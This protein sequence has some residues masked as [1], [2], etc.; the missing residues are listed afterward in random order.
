LNSAVFANGQLSTPGGVDAERVIN[1][2]GFTLTAGGL[3]A[4]LLVFDNIPLRVVNG[5]PISAF[6]NATFRNMDPA[7]TQF[8]L[9]RLNDV[10]TF[11][12]ITFVTEPT[13]GAYLHLVDTDAGGTLFTVTMSGTTPANHGGRVIESLAGQLQGW[14]F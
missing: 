2:A 13:T 12:G 4:N 6:D 14:P 8:R 11:N 3:A 10:V 7:A 1:G 9:D 5:S